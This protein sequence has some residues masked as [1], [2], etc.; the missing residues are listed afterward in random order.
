MHVSELIQVRKKAQVTLP[1]SVRERL[2]IVEGDYLDAQVRD[3]EL[4]LKVKKL[5][6]K[7]Q[8]W[9]WTERWQRGEREA[10]EDIR[11][12]RVH[13]FEDAEAAISYLH[14]RAGKTS[15]KSPRRKA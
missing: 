5:I 4:V 13:Q 2:G 11:A 3:G 15:T 9:F 6:D 7:E 1:Q 10:E 8:A 12:G 14:G